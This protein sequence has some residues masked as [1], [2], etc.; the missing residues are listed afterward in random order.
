MGS[1]GSGPPGGSIDICGMHKGTNERMNI[2]PTEAHINLLH[3]MVESPKSALK[4][5]RQKH[6]KPP[7]SPDHEH[8]CPEHNCPASEKKPDPGLM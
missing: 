2:S 1:I 6:S 3:P 4:L 5:E 7:V 8:C